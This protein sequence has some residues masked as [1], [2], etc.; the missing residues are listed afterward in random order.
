MPTRNVLKEI[1]EVADTLNEQVKNLQELVIK[2]KKTNPLAPSPQ[3]AERT[4]L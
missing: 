2:L 4:E 3:P 1:E